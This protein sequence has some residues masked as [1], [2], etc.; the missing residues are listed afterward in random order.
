MDSFSTRPTEWKNQ[1]YQARSRSNNQHIISSILSTAKV[2]D[3]KQ[4]VLLIGE[5]WIRRTGIETTSDKSLQDRNGFKNLKKSPSSRRRVESAEEKR[6]LGKM[7]KYTVWQWMMSQACIAGAGRL[8][9]RRVF[10]NSYRTLTRFHQAATEMQVSPKP[11]PL[12]TAPPSIRE[13]LGLAELTARRIIPPA[14]A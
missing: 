12:R 6:R 11:K 2:V 13:R 8:D 7:Q 14:R 9:G 10:T 5:W 1:R 3:S 4:G